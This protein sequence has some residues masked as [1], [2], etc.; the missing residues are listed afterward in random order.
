MNVPPSPGCL[1]RAS[2]ALGKTLLMTP[3]SG[4][5]SPNNRPLVMTADA[6]N[7]VG[8]VVA[9]NGDSGYAHRALVMADDR[10]G[11]VLLINLVT[12]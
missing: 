5:P 7:W 10:L 3:K 6:V 11:W 9:V 2:S 1:V 8:V 4:R 12:V